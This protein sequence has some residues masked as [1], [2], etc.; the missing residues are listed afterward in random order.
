MSRPVR[1][2]GASLLSVLRRRWSDAALT[3]MAA[4]LLI[5]LHVA[6]RATLTLRSG[7]MW[8]DYIFLSDVA[9]GEAQGADWYFTPHFGIFM[10]VSFGLVKL[11]GW[12]G[13]SWSVIAVQILVLQFL[14]ALGC[15]WMLR[16]AFGSRPLILVP[17]LLYLATPLTVVTSV[18]WSV[19]INQLPYH[20]ML[21][22]ALGAHLT[23]LRRRSW[24]HAL[25]T[26]AAT[27]LA[28]GSY[29]KGVL[30][31]ILLLAV[32]ITWFGGTTW[33]ARFKAAF[34]SWPVWAGLS[35]ALI[36]YG[37]IWTR[38][39]TDTV[40]SKACSLP[41]TISG[42]VLETFG[43]TLLGGPWRWSLWGPGFDPAIMASRCRPL[44][45]DGPEE[46]VTG[47]APQSLVD[48]PV[49]LVAL[50][51]LV[52]AT[53]L[54]WAAA[55]VKHALAAGWIV[56]FY[57]AISIALIYFGRAALFG[58]Q[59]SALE[60]RYVSDLA[61]VGAFAV[62]TALM[63]M[64]GASVVPTPRDQ[65]F[66]TIAPPRWAVIGLVTAIVASGLWSATQ[67]A[68]PWH[69]RWSSDQFPERYFITNVMDQVDALGDA[70][71]LVVAD[72][73]LP[74][75]V[76]TVIDPYNT[77][78]YKL[79]PLAPA[80]TATRAGND[81]Q[82]LDE[83]G[84]ATPASVA[85]A[86]RVD[87]GPDGECGYGITTSRVI[88][89]V[90]VTDGS[91]WIEI[92]YLSSADGAVTVTA[93]DEARDATVESGVHRLFVQ[94]DGSFDSVIVTSVDGAALCIDSISV[95]ALEP[96]EES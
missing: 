1:D 12:A 94:V 6:F 47:G 55:R 43:T 95:G 36:G 96:R 91:W 46:L 23:W 54:L 75:R 7:F 74:W 39:G 30:I 38:E 67:Y 70:E 69:Q 60:P 24:F 64:R 72:T 11:V 56:V 19:A 81:L 88:P 92:G 22:V 90:P 89:V 66:V 37:L 87:P 3:T 61:A 59:V 4:M 86:N 9:R 80:L 28:M 48:P 26:I 49:L 77:V 42:T 63:G 35:A 45:Y 18:W 31:P 10:P 14:A 78:K 71:R 41:G 93:G 15:W 17:L 83:D 5:G 27:V 32:T 68:V 65:P 85:G 16:A 57:L 50:S 25:L 82:M 8:D 40:M 29:P 79:A 84:W 73:R 34:S 21:F 76:G 58:P 53:V 33:R 44:I 20:A 13:L 2:L 51:W 52:I 62:G